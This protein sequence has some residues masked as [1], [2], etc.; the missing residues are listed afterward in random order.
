MLKQIKYLLGIKNVVEFYGISLNS[1]NKAKCPFHSEKT[2]SFYADVNRNK[3]YC[4]GCSENGDSTDFVSKLFGISISDACKKINEDFNLGLGG[5]LTLEQ[6]KIIQKRVNVESEKEKERKE[7]E[8]LKM[9]YFENFAIYDNICMCR[10]ERGETPDDTW[11]HANEQ[12]IFW[13][14]KYL[15]I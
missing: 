1:K 3:F 15:S 8:A 10:V 11:I 6:K 7:K 14:E 12:R 5:K 4:F 13:Y 2:E 9:Q